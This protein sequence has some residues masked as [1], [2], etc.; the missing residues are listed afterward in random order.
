MQKYSFLIF[1]KEYK[2]FLSDL[3]SLGV[4]HI[5][6]KKA[7]I[8]EDIKERYELVKR[9]NRTIK[10]L[11]KRDIDKDKE[12]PKADIE[13]EGMKIYEDIIQKQ[14]DEISLK[15]KLVSEQKELKKVEPWGNFSTEV[16]EKLRTENIFV[17]FF[18][19]T[20]KKYETEISSKFNTEIISET[21]SKFYFVLL[22]QTNDNLDIDAE[23][24]NI[25]ER[26]YQEINDNIVKIEN[27]IETL[28]N[29]I[30][31]YALNSIPA[32]KSAQSSIS[33]ASDYDKALLN[34]SA[35]AE[36]KI[37]LLE[38]WSPRSQKKELIE[39]LDKNN[40]VYTSDKPTPKDNVPILIKNRKFSRLFEPISKM[41]AFPSYSELDLTPFFAP[42]FM[43]FFGFCLG[44]AGYGLIFLIGAGIAKFK[45]KKEVKP[46][47]SLVQ[48]LGI[49]T[50]IFGAISGTLFGISLI[51]TKIDIFGMDFIRTKIEIFA[52]VK[53]I[54]LD[55]DKMFNLALIFGVI[56]I[57]FGLF[58]N[59]LN[60][61]K[62]FGFVYAL[63]TMGWLIALIGGGTYF[64]LNKLE[65]IDSKIILFIILGIAA[66]FILFF[67]DPKKNV[68]ARIGIGVWDLYSTVTGIFG[69]LL[70]YIRLFALGLSS[71]ILGFVINDIGMQILG[72]GPVIGHILF[73]IF[74]IFGHTLNILIATLGSF[75]HPMRLTFVEFYKNAGFL[76]GGKEYKPFKKLKN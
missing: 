2:T 73:V 30:D 28:N 35:E 45:V 16:I 52:N 65:I 39:F 64:I 50:I 41:F 1:H 49:A 56:Q 70:S 42:F 22:S 38:G 26:N 37:M 36:D 68:F 10:F 74:L 15:Q 4:V 60:K 47:L 14:K 24:I 51:G 20:K 61:T 33:E 54:F 8:S 66:F 5:I 34:T 59:M 43:L 48:I 58:V 44:D 40:T 72:V 46:L 71:A 25:P 3:Q 17:K 6:E 75:V 57:I 27:E 18:I 23:K 62:Q 32:L 9:F 21:K 67:S 12:T 13:T 53:T 76:G 7:E 11:E 31:N 29:V 55:P 69:D 19:A 63:S